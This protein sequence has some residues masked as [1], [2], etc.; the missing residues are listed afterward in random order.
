CASAAPS[1]SRLSISRGIQPSVLS[2]TNAPRTGRK[3]PA[4]AVAGDPCLPCARGSAN[5][6]RAPRETRRPFYTFSV[7]RSCD[8]PGEFLKGTMQCVMWHP[9]DLLAND[10]PTPERFVECQF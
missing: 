10:E 4:R 5:G 9:F 2:R 8:L 3:P 1:R 7:L 6:L